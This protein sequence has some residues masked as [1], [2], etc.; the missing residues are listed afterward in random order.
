VGRTSVGLVSMNI[1]V[2]R[3]AAKI[4]EFSVTSWTC[5]SLQIGYVIPVLRQILV[6]LEISIPDCNV[7]HDKIL[8][9]T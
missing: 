9:R 3:G 5:L 4:D 6:R 7:V 8:V 1:L 2:M